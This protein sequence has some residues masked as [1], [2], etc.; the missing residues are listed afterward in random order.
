MKRVPISGRGCGPYWTDF[1]K[2]LSS[3][4]WLPTET[5]LQDLDSNSSSIWSSKTVENSWFSTKLR[6][7]PN[8]SLSTIF[9]PSLPSFLVECTDSDDTVRKSKKIRIYPSKEQKQIFRRWMG[10]SRKANNDTLSYLENQG[11]T[12][13]WKAIKGE[14]L[15]ALPPWAA[16]TPYQIKSLA[17]RDACIVVSNAKRKCKETGQV[18][19]VKFRSKKN[20]I[21][22]CYIPKSALVQ[23]G[24]YPTLSKGGVRWSED[25]PEK[26]GDCR[27]IAHGDYWYVAIAVETPRQLSEN[28]GKVVALD[29]GIR[30]F[31]TFFAEQSCGKLGCGDFSKIQRLCAHLDKRISL[32]EKEERLFKK[33]RLRLS[34]QRLRVR[35]RNL[36]DELHHKVALFLVKHFDVILLPTFETRNM[37]KRGGRRISRK[38]VRSMLSFSHYR[39]KQFL[40]HKAF[41]YGKLVLDTNEA[42]TSKTVS[43]TG[44]VNEKLGGAKQ[45]RSSAGEV[46]DRDI[47]G[48]RG[49]FLR[50]LGDQ[51]ILK[52]H[53]VDVSAPNPTSV[54]LGSE[55]MIGSQSPDGFD[56]DLRSQAPCT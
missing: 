21:Q 17:I 9:S 7:A 52:S 42:W 10:T 24:V 32:A 20:P 53:L 49:G 8:A 41:E 54:G 22:S 27:L 56:V 47:N 23:H 19:K 18:Q 45:I 13:N 29:P 12:A 34:C 55:K 48:A 1:H 25:I 30:C 3:R 11:T 15:K 40:K 26:H 5:V 16:E 28:Q 6:Q 14:L 2:D 39:F 50:A 36:V 38:S 31:Q 44:E 51:P 37:V 46:M 33:K 4:L 43:W 35:I